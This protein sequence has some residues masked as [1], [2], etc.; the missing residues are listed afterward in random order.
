MSQKGPKA[1]FV[2]RTMEA[3]A[4]E[5]W[6]VSQGGL[7]LSPAPP[8]ANEI[9]MRAVAGDSAIH[10]VGCLVPFDSRLNF[11]K[12]PRIASIFAPKPAQSPDFRR[13]MA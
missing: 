12:K 5:L 13:S 4:Y 2:T 10:R 7:W 11:S 3:L 8:R 6:E 9:H 1:T